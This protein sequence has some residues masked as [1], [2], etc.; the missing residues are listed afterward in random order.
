[1]IQT[2]VW[3]ARVWMLAELLCLEVLL[4]EASVYFV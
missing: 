2:C 1:M 3:E 4:V